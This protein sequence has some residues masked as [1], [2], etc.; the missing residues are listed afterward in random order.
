MP[1]QTC[2]FLQSLAWKSVKST[3]LKLIKYTV[4]KVSWFCFVF[5][6]KWNPKTSQKQSYTIYNLRTQKEKQ[7]QFL[8]WM[9]YHSV[10]I[11]CIYFASLLSYSCWFV[12]SMLGCALMYNIK[13]FCV[14]LML[15]YIYFLFHFHSLMLN[16]TSISTW[17][18]LPTGTTALYWY[19]FIRPSNFRNLN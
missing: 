8:S 6:F 17:D 13:C 11:C 2:T 14:I 10:N 1:D 15:H 7:L 16:K 19:C 3:A 12:W 18:I 9:E 4:S 5:F